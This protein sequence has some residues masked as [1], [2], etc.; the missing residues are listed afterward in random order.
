VIHTRYGIFKGDLLS[1][2]PP[3]LQDGAGQ[4]H[5]PRHLVLG[6]GSF[7]PVDGPIRYAARLVVPVA[8]IVSRAELNAAHEEPR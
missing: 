7:L 6:N 4:I 5:L 1:E 8:D 3:R 2:E